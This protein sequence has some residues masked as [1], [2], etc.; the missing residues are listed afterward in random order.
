MASAFPR[1]EPIPFCEIFGLVKLPLG[2]KP[3]L[4]IPPGRPPALFPKLSLS[5]A[6]ARPPESWPRS[7]SS[8]SQKSGTRPCRELARAAGVFALP[9]RTTT[10][11]Y[12]H[13]WTYQVCR[14]SQYPARPAPERGNEAIRPRAR[15][16]GT[17]SRLRGLYSLSGRGN[18]AKVILTSNARI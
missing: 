1:L 12:V 4:Q 17:N 16:P 7:I 15:V 13:F 6:S 5:S 2:L 3:E 18:D 10:F 11:G 14:G 9:L 8:A